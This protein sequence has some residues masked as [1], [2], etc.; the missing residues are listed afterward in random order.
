MKNLREKKT[1]T[2]DLESI[3]SALV[4]ADALLSLTY[5]CIL[6]Y[7]VR[8]TAGDSFPDNGKSCYLTTE[9]RSISNYKEAEKQ[10]GIDVSCILTC[11]FQCVSS[12]FVMVIFYLF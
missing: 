2:L 1:Y 7:I 11:S 3:I 5:F 4:L 9:L 10:K 12:S 6:N 8:I